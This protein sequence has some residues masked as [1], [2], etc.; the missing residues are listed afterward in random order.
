MN[1]ATKTPRRG[2]PPAGDRAMSPRQRQQ[3]R[4]RKLHAIESEIEQQQGEWRQMAERLARIAQELDDGENVAQ[5]VS[6]A[7]RIAEFNESRMQELAEKP[8]SE[9][10]DKT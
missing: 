1:D 5:A 7:Q 8:T 6:E 2:R 10:A 9:Y 4:R 3:A